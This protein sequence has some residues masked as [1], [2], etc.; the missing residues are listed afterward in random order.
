MMTASILTRR[1][2]TAAATNSANVSGVQVTMSPL[3]SNQRAS[4]AVAEAVRRVETEVLCMLPDLRLGR[5]D[6]VEDQSRRGKEDAP[7]SANGEAVGGGRQEGCSLAGTHL[8]GDEQRPPHELCGDLSLPAIQRG[9]GT[10]G[11]HLRLCR[12]DALIVVQEADAGGVDVRET[13][14]VAASL[15][16]DGA[17]VGQ[18]KTV[19][20][21][22][23]AL[24]PRYVESEG[25]D[26]D[27]ALVAALNFGGIAR[28]LLR[29]P[30]R[31]GLERCLGPQHDLAVKGR[32]L[33]DGLAVRLLRVAVPNRIVPPG[34]EYAL[35]GLRQ[36]LVEN[37]VFELLQL[38]VGGIGDDR[39]LILAV[40]R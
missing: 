1:R 22:A 4:R 12:L 11:R 23:D 19:Q 8:R 15:D 26:G 5:P 25:A 2:R 36:D 7:E 29:S 18:P 10:T 38:R 13:G 17:L 24:G 40:E 28:H 6:G 27:V 32:V 39:N 35:A 30:N 20:R 14:P 33:E 31:T 9:P 3:P 16:L 21:E 34:R 37:E